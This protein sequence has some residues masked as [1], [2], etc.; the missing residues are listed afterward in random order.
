MKINKSKSKIMVCEVT[1]K[2]YVKDRRL[3]IE[4]RKNCIIWGAKLQ[5]L[6]EI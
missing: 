3:N 5:N 2:N 1:D 4:K 6:E